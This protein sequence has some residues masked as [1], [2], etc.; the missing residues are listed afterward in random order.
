MAT[1]NSSAATGTV[2]F[3]DTAS[4][5]ATEL[6]TATLSSG[7]AS[8]ATNSLS[9]GTHILY[10]TYVGDSTYETSASGTVTVTV[11]SASGS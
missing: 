6:G 4:G 8:F 2:I 7:T 11:T 5:T 3:Y 9:V 1:V 10:A